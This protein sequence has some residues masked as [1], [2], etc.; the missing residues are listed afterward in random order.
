MYKEK[1]IL[2]IIPARGGSKGIKDK[3]IVMV[4]NKP[5]I[6]YTL[7]AAKQSQYIDKIIISTD[8]LKIKEVVEQYGF[9]IDSLR[10]EYL[11]TDTAKLIDTVLYTINKEK[12]AGNNYDY[13]ILLQPTSP[14]RTSNNIDEAIKLVID[15]NEISLVSLTIVDNHPLFIRTLDETGCVKRLLNIDSTVRRQDLKPYY[16]VNGALYI[17]DITYLN[18]YS[19][20]NDNKLGYIMDKNNSIDVDDYEDIAYLNYLLHNKNLQTI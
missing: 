6:Y 4:N 17:N 2:A 5:L 12:E 19:S 20:L 9:K 13:I 8:S 18:E 16:Y 3:N 10:P 15:K 14:L 7:E 11:A 1:R